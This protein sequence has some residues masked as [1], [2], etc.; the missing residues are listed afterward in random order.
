M[1]KIKWVLIGF[2]F[3]TTVFASED[4]E[5]PGLI[6]QAKVNEIVC[7]P[8]VAIKDHMQTMSILIYELTSLVEDVIKKDDKV[9]R[10]VIV[11]KTQLLRVHLGAV[12]NLR[13]D[14]LK[15]IHPDNIR[16]SQLVFQTYITAVIS[17]TIEIENELLEIEADP[18][19]QQSEKVK[20]AGLII[21][22]KELVDAAHK[23]FR[24]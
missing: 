12:L 5:L 13:P 4:L 20:V 3:S 14:K 18:F 8:D 7:S 22:L 2:V 16:K 23:A 15:K 9:L 11:E 24:D 19:G 17:K 1:S 6:D 21:N 10:P